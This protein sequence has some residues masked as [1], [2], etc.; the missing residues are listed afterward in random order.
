MDNDDL[1]EVNAQL[2]PTDGWNATFN[3]L[4]LMEM[5]PPKKPLKVLNSILSRVLARYGIC[6]PSLFK[7]WSKGSRTG[8]T[9]Y[10]QEYRISLLVDNSSVV[11][12]MSL[13]ADRKGC[14][15]GLEK[16]FERWLLTRSLDSYEDLRDYLPKL[17]ESERKR[18]EEKVMDA[19]NKRIRG[20]GL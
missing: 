15:K 5:N 19:L 9:A 14:P 8:I 6:H 2:S 20:T 13:Y 18:S 12:S 10:W 3:I 1:I 16:G 17:L 7:I 4:K 11:L